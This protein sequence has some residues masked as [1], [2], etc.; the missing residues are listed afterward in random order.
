ML[1]KKNQIHKKIILA[2]ILSLLTS[3]SFMNEKYVIV[4]FSSNPQGADI[5]IDNQYQGK[6]PS[7]IKIIPNKNY[8]ATFI[9]YGYQRKNLNLETWKWVSIRENRNNFGDSARCFLDALS[10][11]LILPIAALTSVHCKDFTKKNY[12][13]EL[14]PESIHGGNIFYEENYRNRGAYDRSV[15]Y[16]SQNPEY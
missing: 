14:I 8:K 4:P 16:Y 5:Y 9:K 2:I 11:V 15:E 1:F 10:M 12:N 6:T 7:N 13:A 3:C